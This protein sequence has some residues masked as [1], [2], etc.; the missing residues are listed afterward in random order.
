MFEKGK[1]E[2]RHDKED[3]AFN[4]MLLWLAGAVVVEL[5][6]LLLD[7]AYVNMQFGIPVQTALMYFFRVFTILGAVLTA[8]GIVWAVMNARKGDSL[9]LPCACTLVVAELW[10]ASA[11][12]H[13]L[14]DVGLDIAMILPAAAAVLIVIFFLYQRVFFYNAMLAG[15]GLVALWIYRSYWSEHPTMVNAFFIAGFV[16]LA[17]AVVL[18]FVLR[19]GDGKLAGL[20]VVP[21]GTS[22]LMTWVTCVVAAAAMALALVLGMTAAYYLLFILVAW[23]FVQAVFFTVKLM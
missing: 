12:A 4:K 14:F 22:Y 3:A 1:R 11:L 5:V 7:R 19:A 2:Q 17:A 20:R 10:I 6:V 16:A 23:L 21:S 15:G 9:V 8:G 13:F 18:S